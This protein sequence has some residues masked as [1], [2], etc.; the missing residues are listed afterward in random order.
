AFA[1]QVNDYLTDVQ[2]EFNMLVETLVTNAEP[3]TAAADFD[4]RLRT[5][6]Q[7]AD[8]G[9]AV[10]VSGNLLSPCPPTTIEGQLFCRDNGG[11]LSNRESAEVYWN[12]VS[13]NQGFGN[14]TAQ[15]QQP[16]QLA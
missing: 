14:N 6:C 1:K 7:A 4:E 10:T 9:F 16:A 5:N 12:D 13:R 8:V 3:R 11:F 2:R 15:I